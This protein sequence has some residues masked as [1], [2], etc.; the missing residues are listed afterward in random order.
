VIVKLAFHKLTGPDIT[1]V[2]LVY[3][4]SPD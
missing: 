4:V 1:L 3:T 2:P